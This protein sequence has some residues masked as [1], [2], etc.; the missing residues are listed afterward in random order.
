MVC[1]VLP[2]CPLDPPVMVYV[3][4]KCVTRSVLLY[5]PFFFRS[6]FFLLLLFFLSER[7]GGGAIHGRRGTAAAPPP[8]TPERGRGERGEKHVVADYSRGEE[9]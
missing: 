5:V 8:P 7:G 3:S 9:Q 4:I 6:R 2:P 1:G